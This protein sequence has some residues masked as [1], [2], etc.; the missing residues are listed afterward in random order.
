MTGGD[1]ERAASTYGHGPPASRAPDAGSALGTYIPEEGQ[2][3]NTVQF[4]AIVP[5]SGGSEQKKSSGVG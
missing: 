1:A 2:T 3:G 4:M 5:Q